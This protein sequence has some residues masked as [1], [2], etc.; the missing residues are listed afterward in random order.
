MDDQNDIF[1]LPPPQADAAPTPRWKTTSAPAPAADEEGIIETPAPKPVSTS[2]DVARSIA[3]QGTLGLTDIAGFPGTMGQLWDQGTGKAYNYL[4][5]LPTRGIAYGAE[6]LGL[7]PEGKTAQDFIN[8]SQ[9]LGENLQPES[10]K[11]GYTSNIAGINMP[12]GK[13]V[14]EAVQKTLPYTAY[15]P[16]TESGKLAGSAARFATG[17]ATFGAPEAVEQ[18]TA[19]GAAKVLGKQAVVGAASGAGSELA[20]DLSDNIGPDWLS[21]YARF[22]GALAGGGAA[23]GVEQAAKYLAGNDENV[24][25]L[26]VGSLAKDLNTG[27]ASMTPAQIQEA[28]NSGS[29]PSV[30]D[31]AGAQTRD[32]L[33]KYGYLTPD[34]EKKTAQLTQDMADRSSAA[35]ASLADHIDQLFGGNLDPAVQKQ[36]IND[37]NT[38]TIRKLYD[39]ANTSDAAKSVWNDDLASLSKVDDIKKAMRK[40][41]S[42]ATDPDSGITTFRPA[43]EQQE[44][45]TGLVDSSGQP[46]KKII[47]GTEASSPNLMFWDQ[48]K[49]SL[50]DQIQS[51]F[52]TNQKDQARRLLNLKGRLTN[53]LDNAV[54]E[55]GEARNAAADNFGSSNAIEAGY[56]SLKVMNAFKA[57]DVATALSKMTADQRQLFSDGAAGY[58]KEV[59]ANKGTDYVVRM[60]GKPAI[61][62]R[63]KMAIGDDNFNSIYGKAL[64]ESTL[65]KIK[66][67]VEATAQ[68]VKQHGPG[69]YIGFG[70]I[71][72]PIMEHI[73]STGSL[74]PIDPITGGLAAV[75]AGLGWATKAGLN[76]GERAMA[77][78]IMDTLASRDPAK[79]KEL[80]ELAQSNP[81][82]RNALE[83]LGRYSNTVSRNYYLSNPAATPN[84]QADGG[85]IERASGGK[86]MDSQTLVRNAERAKNRINKGTEP[87]L[88]VPDEVITKALAIAN[89]KI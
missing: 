27:S 24:Q 5:S 23:H 48:V 53:T 20:G 49:R 21:P 38:G 18:A 44:V 57:Q 9:Q 58:L 4:T 52:S 71:A 30:F 63:I 7:L 46:I 60:M 11:Q 22:F 47:P 15:E 80:G 36:A 89:E 40:A 67:P 81:N 64:S 77:P 83:K 31:M 34:A 45:E 1:E 32:L 61:A 62:N 88:T 73:I 13:A 6:K 65:S 2:E 55:Y 39:L 42:I 78:K 74:P 54:P 35:S 66:P 86:V 51:A 70:S 50:D 76:V 12:T 25:R 85:R 29:T 16:Q 68:G 10:Q 26:I 84:Q 3:G 56:N 8:A 69:W 17:S 75:G 14:E 33:K 59:A 82:A 87:L 43:S 19:L 72:A 41:N 37:V 28:I 79:I